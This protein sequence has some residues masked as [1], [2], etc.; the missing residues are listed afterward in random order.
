MG[1]LMQQGPGP[2]V[3]GVSHLQETASEMHRFG[4]HLDGKSGV[5]G[6]RTRPTERIPASPQDVGH[7]NRKV[8]DHLA[9]HAPDILD[10]SILID[11]P[12]TPCPRHIELEVMLER[13]N[14]V[15]AQGGELRLDVRGES[16]RAS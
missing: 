15:S 7:A 8:R 6:A 10:L 1:L 13:V 14:R 12:N 4:I 16:L 3:T 9:I 2:R 11:S 5:V